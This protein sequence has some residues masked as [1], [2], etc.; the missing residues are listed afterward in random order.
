MAVV[1]AVIG[2]KEMAISI[3]QAFLLLRLHGIP[4]HDRLFNKKIDKLLTKSTS[5]V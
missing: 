5:N 1:R 2:N 4:S 3:G